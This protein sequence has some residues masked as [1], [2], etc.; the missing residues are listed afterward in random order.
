MSGPAIGITSDFDGENFFTRPTYCRAIEAAGGVP[1]ILPI[2][3]AAVPRTGELQTARQWHPE[4]IHARIADML[5]CVGGVLL[6]GSMGDVPPQRYNQPRHEATQ[7]LHEEKEAFD[8]AL[9]E[10]LAGWPGPVLGICYG[11]QLLNVAMGGTLHQDIPT[12]LAVGPWHGAGFDESRRH[13]VRI[14]PGTR[15]GEIIGASE[16]EVNTTH[17]QAID[18]VAPPLRLAAT[19]V[20]GVTEAVELRESNRFFIGVQWHPERMIDKAAHLRLFEAF[21]AEAR[22]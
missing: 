16:I 11:T 12:Q 1:L 4:D 2:V 18:R 14:E 21:V 20:D 22:R 3:G 7:P 17:H 9:M 10:A 19:S 13:W 5:E 8:F 6:I 15:L